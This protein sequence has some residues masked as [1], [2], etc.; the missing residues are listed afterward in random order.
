M[1]DA[2]P[3]ATTRDIARLAGVSHVTVSRVLR[4]QPS[5]RATVRER[6]FRIVQRVGYRPN[7]LVGTLMAQVQ[8]ASRVRITGAI[9]WLNT[10]PERR[11]WRDRPY[12]RQV[13]A[14]AKARAEQLGFHIDELWAQEKRMTP[15]RMGDILRSRG[16]HGVVVP[17]VADPGFVAQM[18]WSELAVAFVG[19]AALG[20]QWSVVESDNEMAMRL[21]VETVRRAGYRRLGLAVAPLQDWPRVPWRAVFLAMQADWPARQ[22]VAPLR[23]PGSLEQHAEV[24]QAWLHRHRPDVVLGCDFRLKT[25][26]EAAD[27]KVPEEVA[28]VHLHLAEDVPGWAGIDAGDARVG[29]AAVDLVAA[30]LQRNERGV[31]VLP[32]RVLVPCEWRDGATLPMLERPAAAA[33]TARRPARVRGR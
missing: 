20:E 19:Q 31:P 28:V 29:H 10:H 1:P 26:T 15:E 6:V 30:S 33:I 32:R 3:A 5:V 8:A 4:N 12:H 2:L 9:G 21:A 22:R 16:I 27:F 11:E 24:Y 25:L 7:P 17:A 14:G 18:D 23:L 13:L